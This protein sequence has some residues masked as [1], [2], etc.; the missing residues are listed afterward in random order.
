M[1]DKIINEVMDGKFQ[2]IAKGTLTQRAVSDP[3]VFTGTAVIDQGDDSNLRLQFICEGFTGPFD[4]KAG[5]PEPEQ[6]K[7]IGES[8]HFDLSAIDR[9]GDEWAAQHL[10]LD[11]DRPYAL[12]G[13]SAVPS[14]FD[15]LTGRIQELALRVPTA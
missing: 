15:T 7:A 8:F 10:R 9:E 13:L 5:L 3:I 14:G 4:P 1:F 11:L 6:G 2:L 12:P